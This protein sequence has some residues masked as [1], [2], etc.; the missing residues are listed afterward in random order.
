LPIKANLLFLLLVP[1]SI[2]TAPHVLGFS[3]TRSKTFRFQG[4]SPK[5]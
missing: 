5:L 2:E 3:S 4:L 1:S